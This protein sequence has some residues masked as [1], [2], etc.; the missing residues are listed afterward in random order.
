[1]QKLLDDKDSYGN[2]SKSPFNR[3]ERELNHQ[4]K[5]FKREQK[6]DECTQ[7]KLHSTDTIPPAIRG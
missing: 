4:L 3:I 7:K 5:K 1:M 6:I 2:V